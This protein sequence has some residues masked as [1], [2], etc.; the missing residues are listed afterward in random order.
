MAGRQGPSPPPRRPPLK[1]P[2]P[3]RYLPTGPPGLGLLSLRLPP[4]LPLL[5][6]G[7]KAQTA[8]P[9]PLPRPPPPPP[10]P[11]LLV[12]QTASA[13]AGRPTPRRPCGVT[14]LPS[15]RSAGRHRCRRKWPGLTQ[16]AL[17]NALA[18]RCWSSQIS[19]PWPRQKLPVDKPYNNGR[20]RGKEG[21]A[22]ASRVH[23]RFLHP[24]G[25]LCCTTY[26]CA[27]SC[28][29]SRRRS[30]SWTSGGTG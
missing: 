19:S 11:A 10:A 12:R 13:T 18:Y 29:R 7:R 16:V 15:G 21:G 9:Q 17:P 4:P 22:A 6:H 8:P 30:P 3:R 14:L 5:R 20:A 24:A 1:V 26:A 28:W 23:C 25:A 27:S 2:P